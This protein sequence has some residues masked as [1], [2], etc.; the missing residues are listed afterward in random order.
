VLVGGVSVLEDFGFW[1]PKWRF[2]GC[3][4]SAF[5]VADSALLVVDSDS[6]WL[7]TQPFFGCRL[8][9]ADSGLLVADSD[10]NPLPRQRVLQ[11][12]TNLLCAVYEAQT[13]SVEGHGAFIIERGFQ[14]RDVL[15]PGFGSHT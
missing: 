13:G 7:P 15:N 9:V 5:L 12:C 11:P 3:R 8:I 2:F 1:L 4:L 14:Q 6:F 10:R